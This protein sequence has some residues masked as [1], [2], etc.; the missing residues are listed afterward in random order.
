H[1][2]DPEASDESELCLAFHSKLHGTLRLNCTF[3]EVGRTGCF[4]VCQQ[5]FQR[6]SCPC[7]CVVIPCAIVGN[8]EPVRQNR[9][10][11]AKILGKRQAATSR[12]R[13]QYNDEAI[14]S[15]ERVSTSLENE[16]PSP[17]LDGRLA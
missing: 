10:V 16:T 11:K 12:K 2:R 7:N 8:G 15:G 17:Q 3:D 4:G 9:R 14:V 6:V 5:A 1:H 13:E